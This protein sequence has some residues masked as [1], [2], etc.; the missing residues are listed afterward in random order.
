MRTVFFVAIAW[1]G[2]APLSVVA[3]D[4]PFGFRQ[5]MTR[6]QIEALVGKLEV[7]APGQF[8]S[9]RA[10]KSQREFE[11]F[12]LILTPQHGL[13]KVT[14]IGVDI[15]MNSFGSQVQERFERVRTDLEAKYG[16]AKTYDHLRAGSIWD[17]PDDWAMGLL[18]E[19]RTLVAFFN[20]PKVDSVE[21]VSL[22][23]KATSISTGYL[24]ISY[25]FKN[26]DPCLDAVRKLQRSVY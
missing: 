23:A 12:M 15:P 3:Q 26:S 11:S 21:I 19:E 1:I 24:T 8:A 4:G 20:E 7:K 18:K 9:A 10:P 6:A 16:S 2:L 25:E 5:G 13:C 17:D 22:Q 14:A